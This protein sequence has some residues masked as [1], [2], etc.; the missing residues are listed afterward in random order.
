MVNS[1]AP[2]KLGDAVKI[3][4]CARA[5]DAPGRHLDGGR[6]LCRARRGALADARGALVAASRDRRDAA[7]AGVRARAARSLR[8]PLVAALSTR[9][10]GHP[11]IAQ[12]PRGLAALAAI[13]ARAR[14]GRSAGR[15]ACSS[16]GSAGRSPSRLAFGLPHPLLAALVILPALDL[17]GAVPHHP[18]SFGI[19]GGAVAVALASRG[20]GMAEALAIGLAIQARRDARQRR[21]AA[22]SGSPTCMQPSERV[23]RTALRVA[24]V[25]ASAA[26]AALR[27]PRRLSISF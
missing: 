22:R 4:L 18:G 9:L 2:A 27:R 3:A 20:I 19:G 12:L 7:L 25:G 14:D 13:A 11:R 1:F 23:T 8:S 17:A 10:R 21:R 5:I 6:R 24:V 16:R 15:S 26:L